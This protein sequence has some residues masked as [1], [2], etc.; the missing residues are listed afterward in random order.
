[1]VSITGHVLGCSGELLSKCIN[2]KFVLVFKSTSYTAAPIYTYVVC[3]YSG[4]SM[5]DWN[6]WEKAHAI[7]SLQPT[8]PVDWEAAARC[9]N[10]AETRTCA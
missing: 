9:N 2:A 5:V 3:Y 10:G 4:F 8:R 7:K 6:A 1:M